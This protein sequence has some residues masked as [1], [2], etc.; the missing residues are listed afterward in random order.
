ML[1]DYQIEELE[2]K[3]LNKFFHFLKYVEDEMI[4]GFDSKEKIRSDWEHLYGTGNGG[5]DCV[6]FIERKSLWHS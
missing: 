2:K 3:Y 5:K 6:F 4:E 1:T